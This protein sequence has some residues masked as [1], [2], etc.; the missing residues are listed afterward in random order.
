MIINLLKNI[1]ALI[2]VN[3]FKKGQVGFRD[4]VVIAISLFAGGLL[5]YLVITRFY[6]FRPK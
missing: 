3:L 6:V 1:L 5:L 4:I 2:K